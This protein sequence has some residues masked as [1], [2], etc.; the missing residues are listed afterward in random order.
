MSTARSRRE[1]LDLN[2]FITVFVN[3]F[4]DMSYVSRRAVGMRLYKA[5]QT[6]HY[7]DHNDPDAWQ[8][9]VRLSNAAS[10]NEG[11]DDAEG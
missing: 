10:I 11:E 1:L 5:Q 7:F 2:H 9:V 6:G 8:T 3:R 4:Y